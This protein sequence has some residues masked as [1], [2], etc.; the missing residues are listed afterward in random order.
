MMPNFCLVVYN[1]LC[2]LLRNHDHPEEALQCGEIALSLD[3]SQIAAYNNVGICYQDLNQHDKACSYFEQGLKLDPNNATLIYNLANSYVVLEQKELAKTSFET[4][5]SL[6]NIDLQKE[7]T[8]QEP[9]LVKAL[10][11]YNT[12]K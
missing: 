1:N 12:I 9:L 4:L 7:V 11:K 5:F 2:L 10:E 3:P 6:Y 8:T